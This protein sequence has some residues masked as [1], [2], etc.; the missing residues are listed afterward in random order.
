MKIKNRNKN[1]NH[2]QD[3][4]G[5]EENSQRKGCRQER[6]SFDIEVVCIITR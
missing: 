5:T 1:N 4:R 2:E 3:N 6:G